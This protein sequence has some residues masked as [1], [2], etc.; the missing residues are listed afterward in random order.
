VTTPETAATAAVPTIVPPVETVAVIV[1]VLEV[2]VF[3][4]ESFM[5]ITG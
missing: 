1:E 2:T 5:V 3:P 4:P